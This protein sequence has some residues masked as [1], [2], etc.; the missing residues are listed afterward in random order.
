MARRAIPSF[1]KLWERHETLYLDM[2]STALF[3]LAKKKCLITDEDIISEQL[4]P[5]LTQ[6]CFT[7]GKK[8]NA[9]IRTPDWEKPIQPVTDIELKGGNKGK[10]P[11]FTCKCYNPFALKA[12]DAEIAL[13]IE[14]KLLGNPTSKTW[15]LN[16]NYVTN[17]IKRFDNRTH[18]YG[19]RASSGIM[20]GYIISMQPDNIVE[21]VNKWQLK[22]MPQNPRLSFQFDKPPVFYERQTLKRKKVK[23]KNFHLL[24]LWVKIKF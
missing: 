15:I 10:R 16:K 4:C 20:I 6:T 8:R 12:E 18:E 23:P 11:D 7:E 14:C 21:E 24:H 3:Q 17:G 5:I 9:E 1:L 19:K 13:H 2:F 22:H